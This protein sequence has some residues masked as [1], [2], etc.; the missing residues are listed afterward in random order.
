LAVF[1]L[2]CQI[3]LSFVSVLPGRRAN[4]DL[5]GGEM[6]SQMLGG[7][8]PTRRHFVIFPHHQTDYIFALFS[9]IFQHLAHFNG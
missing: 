5:G 2:Q 1:L 7:G 9:K 4:A 6:L 3:I 8:P